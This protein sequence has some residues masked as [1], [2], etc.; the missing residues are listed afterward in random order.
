MKL[1]FINSLFY[2]ESTKWGK[3]E[4]ERIDNYWEYAAGTTICT[5]YQIL[6]YQEFPQQRMLGCGTKRACGEA[7]FA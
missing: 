4:R 3:H 6:I 5:I 7:R 1:G 2:H